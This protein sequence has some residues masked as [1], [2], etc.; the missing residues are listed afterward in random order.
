MATPAICPD[1]VLVGTR[2]M[3]ATL[4]AMLTE[5][6]PGVSIESYEVLGSAAQ[7][8]SSAWN[9]AGTRHGALCELNYTPE[10]SDGSID[11]AK[12]PELYTELD[13]SRQFWAYLVTKGAIRDPRSFIHFVPH[14]SFVRGRRCSSPKRSASPLSAT[15]PSR[16]ARIRVSCRIRHRAAR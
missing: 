6:A 1:V 3:S 16:K 2:I 11:I 7:E 15:W 14:C 8:S 13:L 10:K 4:G 5:L 9:N 12:A